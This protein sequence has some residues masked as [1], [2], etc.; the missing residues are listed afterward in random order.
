MT[1]VCSP[2]SAVARDATLLLVAAD[3]EPKRVYLVEP[4]VVCFVNAAGKA[5]TTYLRAD[6]PHKVVVEAT[7]DGWPV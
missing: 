1:N 4:D 7:V 5:R 3:L 6:G 2:G